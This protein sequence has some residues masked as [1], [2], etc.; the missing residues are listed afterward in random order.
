MAD[1]NNNFKWKILSSERLNCYRHIKECISSIIFFFLLLLF[2]FLGF[3]RTLNEKVN[4]NNKHI[5]KK[6]YNHVLKGKIT[7]SIKFNVRIILIPSFCLFY[8]N[9]F[10]QDNKNVHVFSKTHL[11]NMKLLIWNN[12]SLDSPVYLTFIF[13]L[14]L[15]NF[16]EVIFFGIYYPTLRNNTKRSMEN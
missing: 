10:I 7:I 12:M 11:L 9:F 8:F 2:I 3:L 6:K 15:F 14:I 16:F 13:C 4:N 5:K 1:V